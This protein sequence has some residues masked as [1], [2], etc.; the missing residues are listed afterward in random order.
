MELR[1]I[2]PDPE[3]LL[4]LEVEE[5]AGVLLMH[6]NSRG[7]GGANLHH[8]NFFN[9]FRNNPVYGNP[10]R[11]REVNRAI[12]EAWDWLLHEGFLAKQRD[13]S[14]MAGTFVTRRGQRIKSREDFDAYRK[15]NLLPKGRLHPLI[16]NRV[17]PAFLRGEYDTAIF[18]AFREV[19]VAVRA[20]G[21]YPKDWVG[22]K[23]MRA[24]LATSPPGPLCDPQ[25][26]A[27]EQQ[28]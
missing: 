7:D 13:D 14:S 21:N 6:F 25:L 17:Y 27:G 23:L 9:E 26:P 16:A 1:S 3:V 10:V 18:Q 4:S 28:A 19:E 11:E 8:Y 15:A 24:A 2:I 20:A 5:F 12:M 22:E